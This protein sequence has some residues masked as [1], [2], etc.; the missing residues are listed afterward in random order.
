MQMNTNTSTFS[1]AT[2]TN[3]SKHSARTTEWKNRICTQFYDASILYEKKKIIFFP[4]HINYNLLSV[5]EQELLNII[6]QY[7]YIQHTVTLKMQRH[8]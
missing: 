6:S 4:R 1:T 5:S 3:T 8:W 2:V 7:T